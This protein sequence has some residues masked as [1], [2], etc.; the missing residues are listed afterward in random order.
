MVVLFRMGELRSG[1]I[2]IDGVDT[3]SRT[4]ICMYIYLYIIYIYIYVYIHI[5]VKG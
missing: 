2:H 5:R 1:T 3:V 4:H